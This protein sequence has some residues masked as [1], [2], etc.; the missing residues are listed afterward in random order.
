MV[1]LSIVW[2]S[3]RKREKELGFT[4]KSPKPSLTYF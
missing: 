4:I 2:E 3:S 1:R